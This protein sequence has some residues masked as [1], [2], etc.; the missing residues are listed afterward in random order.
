MVIMCSSVRLITFLF[1]TSCSSEPMYFLNSVVVF[2]IAHIC[3]ALVQTES[4]NRCIGLKAKPEKD[5]FV[6][7][8][9]IALLII[10]H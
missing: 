5:S 7:A 8:E 10:G 6:F 4:Q 9:K 1:E 3:K 2:L